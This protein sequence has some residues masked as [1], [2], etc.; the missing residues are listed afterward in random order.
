MKEA[1]GIVTDLLPLYLDGVCSGESKSLVEQHLTQCEDCRA[2]LERLGEAEMPP[3]D[4]AA[5]L[6]KTA[7]QLNRRAVLAAAG[8]TAIILYWLV[9]FWQDAL[10]MAGNY[11]Y[12]SYSLHELYTAGY[13]LVPGVTALW[14][15]GVLVKGRGRSLLAL[16]LAVLLVLQG[17]L[18]YDNGQREQVTCWTAVAEIP[19]EYHVVIHTGEGPVELDTTPLVTRLLK[20]DGTVYG[21]YYEARQNRPGEGQLCGIWQGEE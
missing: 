4:Q 16:V 3:L 11:R 8:V 1:C 2:L 18:W 21:F 12:F 7:G 13:L 17:W 20:T 9:Y 19:D 10:A 14:L 6:K 5:V 15:L